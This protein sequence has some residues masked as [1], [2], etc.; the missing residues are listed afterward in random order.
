MSEE[1]PKAIDIRFFHDSDE[2]FSIANTSS[3][4]RVAIILLDKKISAQIRVGA[5]VCLLSKEDVGSCLVYGVETA[6]DATSLALSFIDGWV[7]A[8]IEIGLDGY[9]TSLPAE[10]DPKITLHNYEDE[11]YKDLDGT[12]V[13]ESQKENRIQQMRRIDENSILFPM[14]PLIKYIKKVFLGERNTKQAN[15][16]LN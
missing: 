1:L 5:L 3:E 13:D 16:R 10:C 7:N 8:D 6:R 9:P 14:R 11:E 15:F 4:F 12:I 2:N